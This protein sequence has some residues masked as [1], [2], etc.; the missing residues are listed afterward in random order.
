MTHRNR[1]IPAFGLAALLTGAATLFAGAQGRVVGK[2][3]DGAG[4]PLADVKITVTTPAITNFKLE[5]KTDKEGKWQLILNDATIRYRYKF[6]KSGY[7]PFEIEKK[8]GIGQTETLDAQL[9]NP[10]QAVEKGLVKVLEDPF[11]VAFNT[12]VDKLQAG[13]VDVAMEKAEEAIRLGPT[14]SNAYDLGT[15]L[16]V[17]K[18]D[19]VK[20]IEWGEKS[21]SLEPDNPPMFA[22][23]AEAYRAK[24]SKEKAAEYEKR[25]IAA[26]PDQPDVL[27]NQAVELYNKGDAKSA[28][29]I[30]K[31]VLAI[32][33]DHAKA[34]FL[35]GMCYVGL[36]KIPDM[37]VHLNEYLRLDPSGK[38]AGT[39]K[40][41]LEA[42]K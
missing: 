21:L 6:E 7:M 19:W 12:A 4:K 40:E 34:H 27:Y 25:F 28:E 11:V 23:L 13:E 16:A 30:L 29:P 37:K 36:N 22:I 20:A 31:K 26:N 38:D 9:L 17:L 10:E 3:T 14:R 2:V 1:W 18:K 24:G 42:F 41:M 39:A 33:P 8:V 5:V 35:I 15:K 32:K